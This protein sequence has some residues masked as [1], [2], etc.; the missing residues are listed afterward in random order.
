MP[1]HRRQRLSRSPL[2]QGT[3]PAIRPAVPRTGQPVRPVPR[4][5][6]ALMQ[7]VITAVNARG[8]CAATAARVAELPAAEVDG[9][10][11]LCRCPGCLR[12]QAH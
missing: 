10:A 8:M 3:L 4:T 11:A 1:T 5:V 12:Q 7:T 6:A 9:I 2:R